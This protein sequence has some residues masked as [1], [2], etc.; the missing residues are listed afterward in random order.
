[1]SPMNKVRWTTTI[2]NLDIQVDRRGLK[3]SFHMGLV[4]CQYYLYVC[5]DE[6]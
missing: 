3:E 6:L 4:G 2:R 1:M 5:Q